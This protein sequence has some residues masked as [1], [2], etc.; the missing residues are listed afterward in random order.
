[1]IAVAASVTAL[2][3]SAL[4]VFTL[5]SHLPERAVLPTIRQSDPRAPRITGREQPAP[6]PVGDRATDRVPITSQQ[7]N[8]ASGGEPKAVPTRV[9]GRSP[10]HEWN[11]DYDLSGRAE[12]AS[13]V[14]TA[15]L[16]LPPTMSGTWLAEDPGVL[17]LAVTDRN[18]LGLQLSMPSSDGTTLTRLD[19]ILPARN[20]T[21][22]VGF[23]LTAP[24]HWLGS[25]PGTV[26]DSDTTNGRYTVRLETVS[27]RQWRFTIATRPE[28][29]G[30]FEGLSSG[31]LTI[32]ADAP[33]PAWR[34]VSLD[35]TGRNAY[36]ELTAALRLRAR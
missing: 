28:G 18:A 27:D 6:R 16:D 35:L 34:D 31:R 5:R 2:S 13:S 10:V 20:G 1:M 19:V 21:I 22:T 8:E 3:L 25:A 30:P 4:A 23:P 17:F 12:V 15:R 33:R 14:G 36:G 9:V 29:P 32:T 11:R 7:D 24:F 26:Q